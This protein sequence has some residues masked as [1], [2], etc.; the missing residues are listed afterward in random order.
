MRVRWGWGVRWGSGGSGGG[1]DGIGVGSGS[2]AI[3]G[4]GGTGGPEGE[5][6]EAEA[7][8]RVGGGVC[9][10]VGGGLDLAARSLP[11]GHTR[12]CW[13]LLLRLRAVR[14]V[15]MLLGLGAVWPVMLPLLRRRSAG[16][17]GADPV[18]L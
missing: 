17:R 3:G 18:V 1:G 12:G 6:V 7:A 2:G 13:C 14:V 16:A 11:R 9:G 5:D 10:G 4:G 8:A 15:V